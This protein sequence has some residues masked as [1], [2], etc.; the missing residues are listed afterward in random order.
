MNFKN[1]IEHGS[2][3]LPLFAFAHSLGNYKELLFILLLVSIE[4][5]VEFSQI[6]SDFRFCI[7]SKLNYS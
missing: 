5:A 2:D 7:L 4:L 3:F 6:V 1:D